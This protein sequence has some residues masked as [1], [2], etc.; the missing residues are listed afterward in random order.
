M[1][2]VANRDSWDILL[3]WVSDPEKQ[4]VPKFKLLVQDPP[5]HQVELVGIGHVFVKPL[6]LSTGIGLHMQSREVL[7]T[8]LRFVEVDRAIQR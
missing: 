2:I 8:T 7:A 4:N 5:A 3:F 6:D 1:T